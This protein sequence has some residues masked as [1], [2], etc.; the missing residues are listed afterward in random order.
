MYDYE[1]VFNKLFIELKESNLKRDIKIV[2]RD[3]EGHVSV[4]HVIFNDNEVH[5]RTSSRRFCSVKIVDNKVSILYGLTN[6]KYDEYNLNELANKNDEI[7]TV[8]DYFVKSTCILLDNNKEKEENNTNI[9]LRELKT[10]LKGL[11]Q[12]K[13]VLGLI[14]KNK[15]SING[16]Y[17]SNPDEMM[18]RDG[19]D[20]SITYDDN[21][22][23][24]Y[25][26][27]P[28]F[29]NS[30]DIACKLGLVISSIVSNNILI[31]N[32]TKS[33][34]NQ[35]IPCFIWNLNKKKDNNLIDDFKV[36][37]EIEQ[38][39]DQNNLSRVLSKREYYSINMND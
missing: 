21:N 18:I 11:L 28:S 33:Y 22:L 4:G 9:D 30:V 37:Y 12:D 16:V 34:I 8:C 36:E 29:I 3:K 20:F 13:V 25:I 17:L 10:R 26:D 7:S 32:P 24:L 15:N 1:S 39:K 5:W 31:G 38:Q 19:I 35:N 6:F 23:V 2:F 27:N 14:G